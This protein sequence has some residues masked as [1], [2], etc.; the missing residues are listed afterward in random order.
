MS[1]ARSVS[2]VVPV[3]QGEHT[4]DAL[5]GEIAPFVE[6]TISPKG[7]TFRIAEVV[8]VHDGAVDGSAAVMEALSD[9]FPFVRPIWLSRN[10][11]Q[12]AA[13]LA[14]MASTVSEYVVTMDEDGQ[15]TPAAIG[16]MLDHALEHDAQLV[17]AWPTNP[18]P[19]GP[20][21]NTASHFAKWF[22]VHVLG[23]DQI[24]RFNSFRLIEG[25]IARGVAAYG[26]ENIYL[27][28]AL[29]WVVAQ[30]E[31]CPVELRAERGRSSGYT[32]GRLFSHFWTLVLTSGTRP[33]RWI[34]YLGIVS[35]LL[36]LSFSALAVWQKL[37]A[38]I[39]VQ[40]WTSMI[41]VICLFSGMI[42]VSLGI[43]AEYLGITVSMAMG[44]PPYLIVTRP[45]G[46]PRNGA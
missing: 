1:D 14:G 35:I 29:S 18:A 4:L 8:L 24:G 19:H 11:G 28:V 15:Q 46:K 26:G 5:I 17:Y 13:T 22:F 31:H 7:C 34:A 10:F 16:A 2:I 27:D 40:G 37:M 20:L 23:N 45:R 41:I 32:F 43:I 39:P 12:H 42:L 6:P 25:Q 38:Q 36:G 33:L 30:A 3:Y 44:K 21:R 9:K